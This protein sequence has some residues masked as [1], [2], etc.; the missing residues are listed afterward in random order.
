M[1][2]WPGSDWDGAGGAAPLTADWHA[3]GALRHTFTHFHL[4]L[5]VLAAQVP[6]S[7]VPL[8]GAFLPGAGFRPGDLPSLMQKAANL[9]RAALAYG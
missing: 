3:A 8:R 7:A 9:A 6:R 5:T 1:L 4:D 2:G